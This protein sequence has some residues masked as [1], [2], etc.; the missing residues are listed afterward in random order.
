[1]SDIFQSYTD[2]LNEV[3]GD[4]QYNKPTLEDDRDLFIRLANGDC[5]AKEEITIMHYRLVGSIARKYVNK[6]LGLEFDDLLQI[7]MLGL[8]KAI[9]KY[10][11]SYD[12]KFATFATLLIKQTILR[13]IPSMTRAI[14]SPKDK[15]RETSALLSKI[16]ELELIHGKKLTPEEMAD[17][18]GV[19]VDK[20]QEL[21]SYQNVALSYNEIIDGESEFLDTFSDEYYDV[22]ELALQKI[23]N[24]ESIKKIMGFLDNDPRNRHILFSRFGIGGYEEKK[25]TQLAAELG[26]TS[27]GVRQN[28]EHTINKLKKL[29]NE[30]DTVIRKKEKNNKK[31]RF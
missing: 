29:L 14:N 27:E 12:C 30:E 20:Y 10:D 31:S 15:Y 25:L 23:M 5:Y 7:G 19:S 26:I 16:N 13:A 6:K 11:M 17:E 24:L 28:I 4:K 21:L 8:T 2:T 3:Y 22:E 1:M 18:L 9:N